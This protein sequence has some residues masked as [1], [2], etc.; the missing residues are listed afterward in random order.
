MQLQNS[1]T[2]RYSPKSYLP[3]KPGMM[4]FILFTFTPSYPRFPACW[5]I[6]VGRGDGGASKAMFFR[7]VLYPSFFKSL[8]MH[9]TNP[10]WAQRIAVSLYPHPWVWKFLNIFNLSKQYLTKSFST[11]EWPSPS[12]SLAWDAKTQ[13]FAIS[14]KTKVG[15]CAV[16][17]FHS[18]HNGLSFLP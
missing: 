2:I 4:G 3:Q 17:T 15:G 5:Q 14:I 13:V 7:T 12:S 9:N 18:I 6:N 8:I 1:T 10:P 11:L 16:C